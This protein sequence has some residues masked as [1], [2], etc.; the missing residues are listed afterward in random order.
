MNPGD[1]IRITPSLAYDSLGIVE[2]FV[3]YEDDQLVKSV[4]PHHRADHLA[5][6]LDKE[7]K[8][9]RILSEDGCG[10]LREDWWEVVSEN[11]P[12]AVIG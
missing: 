12:D 8:S 7:G 5:I 3:L 9:I 6:I 2:E 4:V 11:H 10:W 1:L